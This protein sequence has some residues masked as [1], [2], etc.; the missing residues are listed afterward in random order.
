MRIHYLIEKFKRFLDIEKNV[1]EHT[2]RN[3]ISDLEQFHQFLKNTSLCSKDTKGDIDI[4]DIDNLVI[5]SYMGYLHKIG[6]RG[7]TAAR[8]LSTLRSFFQYLIREGY[9]DKNYPK[10]VS[11]PKQE[12]RIPSFLSVDDIFKLLE[13]PKGKK[14]LILRDL[15]ILEL[16]YAS[17][18]RISELVNL[19]LKDLN[20][21]DRFVKVLGKGRKERIV[22]L[23]RKSSE[24]LQNYINMRSDLI[25]KG[26][27]EKEGM[28]AL[29]LNHK[30]ERITSRGV[31]NIVI[32][33]VSETGLK[34]KIT[35]HT[36]RHS[37][38]THLLDAGADLRTI[39]EFL[40]HSSLSTTQKYT[41]LTTDRL[42]QVYDKA[43]PRA[44]KKS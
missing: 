6:N 3:Y 37:F 7:K 39:Q 29:F 8:K 22:P 4:K 2:L 25:K 1:S 16:F 19:D 41:H 20:F 42:M 44:R 14:P 17:G 24:A 40:G 27:D 35:P 18:I 13:S 5:R 15:A 12:K 11:T 36:L 34:K 9:T 23:G 38:A 21:K 31:Q 10:M 43:H 28:S 30:G 26:S 33:Y 32:K